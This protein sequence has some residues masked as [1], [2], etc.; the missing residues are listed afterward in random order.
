MLLPVF[1]QT[2]LRASGAGAVLTLHTAEAG[3][4]WLWPTE[5][6]ARGSRVLNRSLEFHG[7]SAERGSV[8]GAGAQVGVTGS[9]CCSLPGH[10]IKQ[11]SFP[12][13]KRKPSPLLVYLL[14]LTAWQTWVSCLLWPA[15]ISPNTTLLGSSGHLGEKPKTHMGLYTSGHLELSSMLTGEVLSWALC[16]GLPWSRIK[17][18]VEG[19]R[20]GQPGKQRSGWKWML[21]QSGYQ[22]LVTTRTPT[23]LDK[24][25]PLEGDYCASLPPHQP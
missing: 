12:F 3:I 1:Q 7:V 11:S 4:P 21:L 17:G 2:S 14:I 16:K 10:T 23:V 19:E 25:Q 24:W 15:S 22:G 8:C 20:S 9:G 5:L 13:S 6:T 18:C